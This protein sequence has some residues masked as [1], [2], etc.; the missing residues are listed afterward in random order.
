[1]TTL[2]S[3]LGCGAIPACLDLDNGSAEPTHLC[4]V[5]QVGHPQD[6]EIER[7]MPTS[8]VVPEALTMPP[9]AHQQTQKLPK[10]EKSSLPHR[11]L[12][13]GTAFLDV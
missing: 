10:L 3:E 12:T 6:P 8:R 4:S 11:E 1:M 9:H 2:A 7:L 13:S 5:V